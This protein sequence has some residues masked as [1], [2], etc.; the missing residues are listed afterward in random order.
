MGWVDEIFWG[1]TNYAASTSTLIVPWLFAVNIVGLSLF[2]HTALM[3]YDPPSSSPSPS[4]KSELNLCHAA[5]LDIAYKHKNPLTKLI[6][7]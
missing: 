3:K 7:N 1:I 2:Q 4:F 6:L 5:G